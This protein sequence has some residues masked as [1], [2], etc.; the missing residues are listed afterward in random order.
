MPWLCV[1][2]VMPAHKQHRGRPRPI[3]EGALCSHSCQQR[4]GRGSWETG[5]VTHLSTPHDASRESVRSQGGAQAR[6]WHL[7]TRN[8][9]QA[10]RAR[11]TRR[12]VA[13]AR[14]YVV[15]V[16]S[17]SSFAVPPSCHASTQR[18]QREDEA[19]L[20]RG[21]CSRGSQQGEGG[22]RKGGRGGESMGWREG[23]REKR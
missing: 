8:R 10:R 23:G 3:P 11:A 21:Q 16:V 18:T 14:G 1:L 4:Q 22:G 2:C 5:A 12:Y 19:Y 15:L 9:G 6:T 20:Q 7:S 13:Y 17:L